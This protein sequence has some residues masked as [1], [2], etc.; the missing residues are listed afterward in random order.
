MAKGVR[1]RVRQRLSRAEDRGVEEESGGD[2]GDDAP[3]RVQPS[4]VQRKLKKRLAFLDRVKQ[5]ALSIRA[6]GVAKRKRKSTTQLSLSSLVRALRAP[7]PVRAA[8][9]DA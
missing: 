4:S 6:A 7:V 5:S 1:A 9:T 3:V 2:G 8:D